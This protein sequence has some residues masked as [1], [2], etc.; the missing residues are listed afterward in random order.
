MAYPPK[1]R[2]LLVGAILCGAALALFIVLRRPP[3]KPI[4]PS[5]VSV[6]PTQGVK[7]LPYESMAA[8]VS[9]KGNVMDRY[10][11]VIAFLD[12]ATR[13][14]IVW[15]DEIKLLVELED[16]LFKS[17]HGA[18]VKEA[19]LNK[20]AD[21]ETGVDLAGLLTFVL[22]ASPSDSGRKELASLLTKNKDYD[23]VIVHAVS[24]RNPRI[25]QDPERRVAFWKGCLSLME[26]DERLHVGFR[27]R[28][29]REEYGRSLEDVK[30][31]EVV[32][33]SSADQFDNQV[34]AP[35]HEL[36]KKGFTTYIEEGDAVREALIRYLQNGESPEAKL[37]ICVASKA[38]PD[39]ANA[40]RE[41]FM[42]ASSYP[43]IPRR[44]LLGRATEGGAQ[45]PWDT[46]Y[47]LLPHAGELK[48]E[49]IERLAHEART[50]PTQ[51]E[52]TLGIVREEISRAALPANRLDKLLSALVRIQ[53]DSSERYFFELCREHPSEIVRARSAG[54]LC[55]G[56]LDSAAP[57]LHG[58][59]IRCAEE[60]LLKDPSAAVQGAAATSLGVLLS[61]SGRA[62]N[63]EE[64]R[65]RV[66][67]LIAQGRI[68]ERDAEVL[69]ESLDRK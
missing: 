67:S 51:Q 69:F 33:P 19:I 52:Q 38:G 46:L 50:K 44:S 3:A 62:S 28:L 10:R 1:T 34:M 37:I 16:L 5:P 53:S 56:D 60:A 8:P 66:R 9:A 20:L 24:I 29:F 15:K 14:K 12:A 17:E 64:V 30:R 31:K 45:G 61:E 32:K 21:P 40:A 68:N 59:R 22:T 27:D 25:D 41:A 36:R 2:P 47:D 39:L 11:E 18:R 57:E 7:V 42:N 63:P 49:M 54:S 58:R 35:F 65:I 23:A 13:L 55:S 43:D 6:A 26:R 48:L 4:A